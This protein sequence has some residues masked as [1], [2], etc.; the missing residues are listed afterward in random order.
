MHF[1]V[2]LVFSVTAT[3]IVPFVSVY[4]KGIHDVNYV[5]PIF[6]MMLTLAW[7][8]YCIR[9][10]YNIAVLAVG[11]YKQTQWS[12]VIEAFLNIFM[13]IIFVS[14]WGI[15]GVACATFIAMVYRICYLAW[16]IS[17]KIINRSLL[18]FLKHI[19]VDLVSVFVFAVMLYLVSG[20]VYEINVLSYY[21]WIVLAVKV[22]VI[23]MVTI[24]IV[25]SFFYFERIK[26]L[27]RKK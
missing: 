14:Q 9:L 27:L 10:H 19:F 22:T 18:L 3:L 16:Y 23:G 25:N 21:E 12:A 11:H 15:T 24:T 8:M 7:G 6:G 1:V 4:T 20:P 13:A 26:N 17:R 2:S 5:V